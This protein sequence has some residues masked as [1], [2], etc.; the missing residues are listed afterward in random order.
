MSLLVAVGIL[1]VS[2][3]VIGPR[4]FEDITSA[5]PGVGPGPGPPPLPTQVL[6]PQD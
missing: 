2:L 4:M 5:D 6:K 1:L 3:A